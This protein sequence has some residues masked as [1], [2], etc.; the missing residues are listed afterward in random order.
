MFT[1]QLSEPAGIVDAGNGI[2]N[3]FLFFRS[4][5]VQLGCNY[6]ILSDVC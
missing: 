1:L 2:I 5:S 4:L 6:E 3:S